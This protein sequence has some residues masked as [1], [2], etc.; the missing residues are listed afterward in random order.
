[1]IR[2]RHPLQGKHLE[3]FRWRHHHDTLKLTLVLPDGSR[4]EIPAA[5]TD[6]NK[7]CPRKFTLPTRKSQTDLIA[8][9]SGFLH[10]RKIVDDLLDKLLSS[11]QKSSASRKE[12]NHAQTAELLANQGRVHANSGD[13]ANPEPRTAATDNSGSCRTD[14]KNCLSEKRKTDQGGKQ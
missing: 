7:K 5:W 10:T 8:T 13:L 12:N 2:D 9:A 14:P 3:L 11:M 4:A 1:M 6:L